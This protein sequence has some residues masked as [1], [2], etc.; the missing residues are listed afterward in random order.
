MS[1]ETGDDPTNGDDTTGNDAEET[2][3]ESDGGGVPAG[4]VEL[5]AYLDAQYGDRFD[6][7]RREELRDRVGSLRGIGETLSEADLEN[8]DEPAFTFAAYRGDE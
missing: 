8:G 7:D 6:T 2:G 4:T 1:D 3:D 5:L